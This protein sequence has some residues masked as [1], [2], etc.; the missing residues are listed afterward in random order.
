MKTDARV[1]LYIDN[2]Q[3]FAKPILEYLRA[4]IH[5][6]CPNCEETIKWGFPHFIY[7][8]KIL[9]A[10][11]SFKAHAAFGFWL[12]N[13]MQTMQPL[14]IEREKNS[15]FQLG[16]LKSIDDLPTQEILISAIQ[17]AMALTESGAIIKKR[18]ADTSE[19]V[20]PDDFQQRLD[21]TISAK[22]HFDQFSLAQRRDYVQ[23]IN[24]AKTDNTRSKRINTSIEWLS[25][26][27]DRNW[28]YKKC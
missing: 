8:D 20:V 17:E 13:E 10:M 21:D 5:D 11:S 22:S 16:K 23:W 15:M 25:E 26:G 28:K 14:I 4:L 18:K 6:N 9:C 7:Q 27:K 3:D 24:E 12:E 19:V 1:D 2:A